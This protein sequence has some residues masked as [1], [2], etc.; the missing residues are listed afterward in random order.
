MVME[1]EGRRGNSQDSPKKLGLVKGYG[2]RATRPIQLAVTVVDLSNLRNLGL[3]IIPKKNTLN[4]RTLD[5][6]RDLSVVIHAILIRKRPSI[7]LLCR[8]VSINSRQSH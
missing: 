5:L 1:N 6:P 8:P 3:Q 7:G 4:C 2:F